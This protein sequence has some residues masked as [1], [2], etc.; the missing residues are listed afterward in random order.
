MASAAP[1]RA[2]GR[3]ARSS[4]PRRRL[5]APT[6]SGP[7]PSSLGPFPRRL[8]RFIRVRRAF[9]CPPSIESWRGESRRGSRSVSS[10]E[11]LPDRRGR[12]CAGA[13]PDE[14]SDRDSDERPGG[15]TGQHRTDGG[16]RSRDRTSEHRGQH[17]DD[18]RGGCQSCSGSQGTKHGKGQPGREGHERDDPCRHDGSVDTSRELHGVARKA[19]QREPVHARRNSSGNEHRTAVLVVVAPLLPCA[20][21]PRASAKVSPQDLRTCLQREADV[22]PFGQ[23]ARDQDANGAVESGR[24]LDDITLHQKGALRCEATWEHRV[25]HG[26]C[27]RDQE[28][29][30]PC[31]GPGR[32]HPHLSKPQGDEACE[33]ERAADGECTSRRRLG[34]PSPAGH[35][36]RSREPGEAR[37]QDEG[38]PAVTAP[39]S[40]GGMEEAPE[41]GYTLGASTR[42][43]RPSRRTASER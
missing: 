36:D 34:G 14:C 19:S 6:P 43:A 3:E 23:G 10:P 25:Q 18:C 22:R 11:S 1:D 28:H 29:A 39:P 35:R 40:R 20:P 15:E 24:K 2:A 8:G 26:C 7:E 30:S 37:G 42:A 17:G 41:H 32:T 27:R 12:E 21:P 16:I 38:V 13:N 31:Q 5:A 9:T 33:D 4:S